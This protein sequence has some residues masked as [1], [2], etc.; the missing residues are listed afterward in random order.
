MNE[1][2]IIRPPP[3]HF[4][5]F[6]S[7]SAPQTSFL[8]TLP[9]FLLPEASFSLHTPHFLS[10][11]L[12]YDSP[13]F[14]LRSFLAVA[15]R[16]ILPVE[17]AK[18]SSPRRQSRPRRSLFPLAPSARSHSLGLLSFSALRASRHLHCRTREVEFSEAA[19]AAPGDAFPF[20]TLTPYS[21]HHGPASF[22][23]FFRVF[24]AFRL[25]NHRMGCILNT[26][27]VAG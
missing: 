6:A 12:R 8:L 16:G 17:L 22:A 25:E 19:Q 24:F 9:H 10:F 1:S 23:S 15:P 3:P 20:S 4:A 14:A 5:S 7:F 11:H 18:A 21:S 26:I 27:P 13:G 2:F